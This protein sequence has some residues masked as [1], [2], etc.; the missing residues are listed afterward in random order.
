MNKT[1]LRKTVARNASIAPLTLVLLL[2][3]VCSPLAEKD[4][5]AGQ[6]EGWDLLPEILSRIV[7]PTF[8]DRDFKVTD[9]G[10]VGDGVTD[11]NPAFKKAIAACTKAGGGRVVVPKGTFLTNGPIH[12]DNNVNLHVTKDA[13]I[14]FGTNF[15]DYLPHVRVRWEGTECYNYS[16][17]VYAYKKTN[18][19][20]TGSGTLNGQAESSWAMWPSKLKPGTTTN[21]ELREMNHKDVP[22]EEIKIYGKPTFFEPFECTNVLIED[23]TIL[24]YPFWCIHPTFCTNVTIRKL[25]IES[26]NSNNDGIDPDSS[27]DVLIEDCYLDQSDDCLAIKAGRDNSAWRK[28]RACE[29]IVIRNMPSNFGGIAIG[30]EIAGGV[31]NVFFYDSKYESGNV[32]YCK[33]NLD[34]GGYI[35]DIYIKNLKIGKARI[36]RLRNNYHGYRGGNFPTEFRNI[37]IEDVHIKQGSDEMIS[38]QGVEGALVYDVFIK[39][40]TVDTLEK[41][42]IMHLRNAENVVLTNVSIAGEI[43]PTN[44]PMMPPEEKELEGTAS[45]APRRSGKWS[46]PSNWETGRDGARLKWSGDAANR[47]PDGKIDG[48]VLIGKSR[49]VPDG[50]TVTLDRDIDDVFEVRVYEQSTFIIPDG[51]TFK[52]KGPFIVDRTNSVARQLGGALDVAKNLDIDT[53]TGRYVITGGSLNCG[54]LSLNEGMFVVD[55]SQGK[56]K[57]V[58]VRGEYRTGDGEGN[59]TTKFVAHKGGVTPVQC[60]DLNL[61]A[62]IG[63]KLIVDVSAYDYAKNGDLVLFSYTGTRK[64]EFDGGPE[65]PT[66]QV[67]IIGAKADLVYDDVGKKIKLTNFR[68]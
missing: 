39:N 67:S 45:I 31:R 12:L 52:I 8:P 4:S 37:N 63:E 68:P 17:L 54:K 59:T 13:T 57:S 27:K 25:R 41:G 44:P 64:G 56:I 7:P 38:I 65:K 53:T 32:L 42:P 46:D 33:S 18:I 29:N 22:V 60:Q 62:Y 2:A 55:D 26:H 66:P 20:I 5:A 24:D 28:G 6:R 1:I 43:Q 34:R 15:D 9:Y 3:C 14:M 40:V 16:P 21:E 47:L 11:C 10:A 49:V 51:Y 19:A 58:T 48:R 50:V 30:S 61:D 35:K 23:V 36:L